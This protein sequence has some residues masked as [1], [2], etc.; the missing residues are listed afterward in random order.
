MKKTKLISI[1]IPTYNSSKFIEETVNSVFKQTYKNWEL[2]IIDDCSTDNTFEILE[3]LQKENSDKSIKILK[4][5][6]N[7][8]GPFGPTNVAINES[9]GEYIALLDHDDLWDSQKLQRQIDFVSKNNLDF[10]ACNLTYQ[11]INLNKKEKFDID[12]KGNL[13]EKIL[14]KNI[15]PT[16][17]VCLF[18]KEVFKKIKFRDD[19]K[20][21]GDWE[22]F[23]RFFE[24]NFKNGFLKDYF[25]IKK[26]HNNNL[27]NKK[28]LK[29]INFEL[30]EIYNLNK[31]KYDSNKKLKSNTLKTFGNYYVATS[32]LNNAKKSYIESFKIKPN[33]YSLFKIIY[34]SMPDFA[35][36]LI[37]KYK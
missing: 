18:K 32:N 21:T 19:F 15:I 25:V 13:T 20:I 37:K 2:I 24:I 36:K 3:K 35:I 7:F 9:K 4:T 31:D 11:N 12:N 34:I 14:Y 5:N 27:S 26:I 1:I 16:M 33:F 23:I 17:P 28:D 6:K 10:C 8:G 30:N 22:F 29:Q